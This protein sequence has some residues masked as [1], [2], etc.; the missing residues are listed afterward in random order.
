VGAGFMFDNFY[1][2]NG[3][4]DGISV[5]QT[6]DPANPEYYIEN[7]DTLHYGFQ[8]EKVMARASLD[9]GNLL[10]SPLLSDKDL[11]LY[12]ESILMGVRDYPGY[13]QK[14]T[15][16]IACMYGVNLPTFHVLDL[17]SL[18][19]EYYRNPMGD[20]ISKVTSQFAPIPAVALGHSQ[21]K[22]TIYARKTI[23]RGFSISAQAANDHMRLVDFYGHT[24]DVSSMQRT[25]DW[26]WAL[27]LGYSI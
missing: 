4:G 27:Q 9:L 5:V 8:G 20:N 12:F 21:W 2:P 25:K 15:D 10:G 19:F 1:N 17:L 11:R 3:V 16:R 23:V 14:M 13:Y 7:G 18:E 24:N 22:W 26:Y 6:Y